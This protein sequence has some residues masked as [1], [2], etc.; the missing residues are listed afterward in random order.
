MQDAVRVGDD[1][2]RQ[3]QTLAFFAHSESV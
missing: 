3:F 1:P 2:D